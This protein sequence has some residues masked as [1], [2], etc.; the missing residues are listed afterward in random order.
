MGFELDELMIG[1]LTSRFLCRTRS[2]NDR[3]DRECPHV[4]PSEGTGPHMLPSPPQKNIP[5]KLTRQQ[6]IEAIEDIV[7][8]EIDCRSFQRGRAPDVGAARHQGGLMSSY[9]FML[10]SSTFA[11]TSSTSAMSR[12]LSSTLRLSMRSIVSH[13]KDWA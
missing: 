12:T 1:G 13:P 2:S 10:Q 4:S 3:H 5:N 6:L 7:P 8:G 9:V 11:S